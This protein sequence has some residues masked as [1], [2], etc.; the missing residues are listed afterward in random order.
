MKH[1]ATG[2]LLSRAGSGLSLSS[3]SDY[4]SSCLWTL[5]TS[6]AAVANN[7]GFF[8]LQ[9][10][11]SSQKLQPDLTLSSNT[12]G[13]RF[14]VDSSWFAFA[15]QPSILNRFITTRGPVFCYADGT[16]QPLRVEDFISNATLQPSNTA[17]SIT[18][19][20]PG[21]TGQVT[22]NP[23]STPIS[24][25]AVAYITVRDAPD[26]SYPNHSDF[27]F[28]LLYA[29]GWRNLTLRFNNET[30]NLVAARADD[31]GLGWIYN[32]DTNFATNLPKGSNPL[33]LVKRADGTTRLHVLVTASATQFAFPTGT[34]DTDVA[35]WA[36]VVDGGQ[37]T[38]VEA[39]MVA[40]DES[41]S[42]VVPPD[43]SR[44]AGQWGSLAT[45][46]IG[47]VP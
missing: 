38:L 47:G 32:L 8:P 13:V 30:N 6:S 45:V 11:I 39:A 41:G 27:T 19:L 5:D 24:I 10:P 17:A 21:G 46:F 40:D 14:V 12:S 20:L 1:A 3:T 43:W 31:N 25:P 35:S 37:G 4:T 22:F 7:N 34:A 2:S 44:W 9:D 33:R 16:Q 28:S 18:S 23:P 29:T 36:S 15:T 26:G 42:G